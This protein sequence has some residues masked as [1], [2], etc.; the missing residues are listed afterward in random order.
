MVWQGSLQLFGRKGEQREGRR[1][2][3][4]VVQ[5]KEEA[6]EQS[7]DGMREGGARESI[8]KAHEERGKIIIKHESNE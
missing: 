5:R 2:E 3:R 1:E 7:M 6:A 8:E 4:V